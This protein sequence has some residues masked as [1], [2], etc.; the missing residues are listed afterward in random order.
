MTKKIITIADVH[1]RDNWK[2]Q[3]DQ[4]FDHCV[5]LGDY[6]D[7]FQIDGK[8]QIKNFQEILAFK[9]ENPEKVTLLVGN[10]D[11]SYLDVFCQCSGYQNDRAFQIKNIL[12]PLIKSREIQAVKIIDKY[13]F[14]HAGVTKTWMK[15]NKIQELMELMN[16]N[17]EEAVNELFWTRVHP[18]CF[19]DNPPGTLIQTIS[20][21][22]DNIWQSPT[23]VRPAS[24]IADKI[25]NYI[26]VVGHTQQSK[27][28]FNTD[29]WFCDC[30]ESTDEILIL[31]I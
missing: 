19:Q 13:L 31:E 25:D 6:F 22:G 26:Q 24:L 4:E 3:V 30:Q 1:G 18:F 15:A 10:H 23:W 17:L 16:C 14:V 28:T 21:Y 11:V 5:F 7:S 20:Y 12:E 29:V 9:R 8:I 27:P 2:Q